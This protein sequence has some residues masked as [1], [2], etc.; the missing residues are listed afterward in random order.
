VQATWVFRRRY[1]L[2]LQVLDSINIT[3]ITGAQAVEHSGLKFGTNVS[4][5]FPYLLD[6]VGC[7]GS[8]SNLLNCLPDHNCI[9]DAVGLLEDAGVQ[10]LRKG[11]IL[12]NFQNLIQFHFKLHEFRS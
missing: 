6:D 4:A 9:S 3:I 11:I 8:E 2:N 12:P 7:S 1:V 5:Y 10:C